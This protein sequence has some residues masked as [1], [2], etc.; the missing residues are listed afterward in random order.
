MARRPKVTRTV[1]TTKAT[2]LCVNTETEETLT[3]VV[4]V[5]RTYTDDKKLL[6]AVKDVLDARIIP[7]KVIS[8][9][10]VET[11]YGMTE[12][13]FIENAEKLP[14]RK[15]EKDENAQE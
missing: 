2:L 10:T 15:T 1:T 3:Q 11:L 12:Q 14:P 7:V 6:N 9:E 4:E 5:P 8:T 13:K